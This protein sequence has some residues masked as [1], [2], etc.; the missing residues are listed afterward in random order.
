MVGEVG[1]GFYQ[2][3]A[4]LNPERIFVAMEAIGIGRAA[5]AHAADY[6][7]QRVVFD[8]PIGANQ[9][10]AHPLARAWAQLEAAELVALKAAW[11]ADGGEPCGAEANTAKL[12]AAEAGFAACDAALQTLGGFGYAKEYH[13]ERW[14][15][16]VRLYKI[17]PVS[18]ELALNY[19]AERALH[20]PRS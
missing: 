5:L 9:A 7:S 15:R 19:L 11:L 13:V 3:L 16:E 14:W 17:A 12:L 1:R 10:I 2:L 20:L 6:A 8:R 18:Q 4:A